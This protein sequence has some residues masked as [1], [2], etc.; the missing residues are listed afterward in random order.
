VRSFQLHDATSV[1]EA[2]ELLAAHGSQARPLGGG[3]DLVAGIMRDQIIGKG[4]PYPSHLVDITRVPEM[5][6]IRITGEGVRIGAT[7]SLAEMD[8][9][10]GL[11]RSWPVLAA[12][13]ADVASPEIR[14][15]GT[16]GGNLHQRPR[17]WFFRNK[18]FDCAKKGGDICFAVKGDN[19]YNAILG[20]HLCYIVHPS[21]LATALVALGARARVASRDGQRNVSFDDYFIGPDQDLL[22]ENVLR[23]DELLTEIDVPVPAADTYQGWGKL[24]EKGAPTWDFALVSVAATM[25]VVD[26][27]WRGGRIVLGGVAPVPFRATMVEDALI[28]NDVRSALPDAIAQIRSIARP[29]PHNAYKLTLVEHLVPRVIHAALERDPIPA[30]LAGDR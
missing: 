3:T 19:R 20:G 17:C 23:P 30:P 24:N 16:V 28:G 12:A 21:D 29:M 26:G 7:T 18:D 4:M 15:I 11:R 2:T 6:G 22:R 13:A 14:A 27:I 9:S 1:A 8:E 25:N 10:S 5:H